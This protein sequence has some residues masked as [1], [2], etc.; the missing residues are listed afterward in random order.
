MNGHLKHYSIV[1]SVLFSLLLSFNLQA[2][3]ISVKGRAAPKSGIENMTHYCLHQ[4]DNQSVREIYQQY[5][6][7]EGMILTALHR[8]F[9]AKGFQLAADQTACELEMHHMLSVQDQ[10]QLIERSYDRAP[11]RTV[12]DREG[13]LRRGALQLDAYNK[14]TGRKIWT[15]MAAQTEGRYINLVKTE[16][17][18]VERTRKNVDSAVDQLFLRFPARAK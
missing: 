4:F 11:V 9:E 3:E 17:V 14:E 10:A 7:L 12:T 5:P 1:L 6:E 18:D 8:N 2:E 16:E 15:G 13:K